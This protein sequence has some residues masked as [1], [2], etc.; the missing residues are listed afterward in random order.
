MKK[1]L[2][3]AFM[4]VLVLVAAGCSPAVKEGDTVEETPQSYQMVISTGGTSGSYFP[5]GGAIANVISN[6]VPGANVTAQTSGGS[7]ENLK[8]IERGE[9][10]MGLAQNDLADFAFRGVEMFSEKLIKHRAIATFYP[11][12]IQIVVRADKNINNIED[13]KGYKIS[14][15]A[16]GSGSEANARQFLEALGVPYSS[17][18]PQ[19]LSNTDAADQFKD[20]IIDGMMITSGLPSPAITDIALLSDV[21]IL[22][23]TEEQLKII[24]ERM[25][26]LTPVTITA[27]TYEG[28]DED[29]VTVAAQAVL[30]VSEDIPEDVVYECTKALWEYKDELIQSIPK[31][32]NMDPKDP[33]K[34]VTTPVHPGAIKYYNEIGVSV[35]N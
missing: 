7:V 10:E 18:N 6:H 3:I 30:F 34:G 17:F 12:L 8:L 13:L 29:V 35:N 21:K 19:F 32:E 24:N 31:A 2:L 28:Q 25:P 23:F 26:F 11:E 16:P 9:C 20:K 22:G 27:G 15:G 33:V 4:L 1:T 5:M 14:V